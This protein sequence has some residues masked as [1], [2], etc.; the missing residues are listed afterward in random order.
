MIPRDR[1]SYGPGEAIR[2]ETVERALRRSRPAPGWVGMS[3]PGQPVSMHHG[4]E[5]AAEG[6]PGGRPIGDAQCCRERPMP[7][8]IVVS[9][10]PL[11]QRKP[12]QQWQDPAPLVNAEKG[13]CTQV[14]SMHRGSR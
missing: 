9:I 14:R 4:D 6:D 13:M 10:S 2:G 3:H 5:V 8:C 11:E 1:L 12:G 7:V